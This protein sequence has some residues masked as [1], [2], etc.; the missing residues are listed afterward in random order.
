MNRVIG[1]VAGVATSAALFVSN[2]IAQPGGAS[3]TG[4]LT[5][6]SFGNQ[7]IVSAHQAPDGSVSGKVILESG[8]SGVHGQSHQRIQVD[9]T[10][11]QVTGSVAIVGGTTVR[12]T[13]GVGTVHPQYAFVLEDAGAG[14]PDKSTIFALFATEPSNPCLDVF[15]PAVQ[16]SVRG[17][18][19]V[20]GD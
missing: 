19:V 18:I 2:G 8:E 4:N 17:N 10:C 9:V 14:L 16:T 20:R 5:V 3:V 15:G 11:V 6:D 13:E 7:I 12:S 1:L